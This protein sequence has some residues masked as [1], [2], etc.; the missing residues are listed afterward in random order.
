MGQMSVHGQQEREYSSRY[1]VTIVYTAERCPNCRRGSVIIIAY[2]AK[3]QHNTA[4]NVT[5]TDK[6]IKKTRKL[7]RLLGHLCRYGY[8]A[9]I[10]LDV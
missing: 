2:Y 4:Q 8:V 7:L 6:N 3:R 5:D 10:R 9:K 1:R